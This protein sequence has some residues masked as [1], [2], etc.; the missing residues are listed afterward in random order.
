LFENLFTPDLEQSNQDFASENSN[1]IQSQ[2]VRYHEEEFSGFPPPN[3][4]RLPLT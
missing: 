4:D 3:V 2:N 1:S